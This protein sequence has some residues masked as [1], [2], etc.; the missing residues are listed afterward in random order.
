ML[1]AILYYENLSKHVNKQIK[2][3]NNSVRRVQ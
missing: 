1:A 3:I 2:Q